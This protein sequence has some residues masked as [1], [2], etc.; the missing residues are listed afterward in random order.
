MNNKLE[1]DIFKFNSK[2]NN[3]FLQLNKKNVQLETE[4][5]QSKDIIKLFES[6][7]Y[8][9]EHEIKLNKNNQI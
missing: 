9:L 6:K 8:Q 7:I 3:E 4:L 5:R 2:D 1:Y